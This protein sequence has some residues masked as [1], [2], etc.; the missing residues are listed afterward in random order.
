MT[1]PVT[2]AVQPDRHA[3]LAA[4]AP[5]GEG[6]LDIGDL[7]MI[8]SRAREASR[9]AQWL[10]T[11]AQELLVQ[12]QALAQVRAESRQARVLGQSPPL[13]REVLQQSEY[14]R[15]LARLETL[16]VIEQAKGI[17]MAQSGC[18]DAEAFDLLRRASQRSNVPVREL[19]AQFV[20][21]AA[22]GSQATRKPG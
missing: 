22:L 19:A 7:A 3:P 4:P 8:W 11:Q 12:A 5:P 1:A 14:L 21:K 20:A 6:G 16:P 10:I 13:R 18:S 17:L 9:R 15:L 2:D